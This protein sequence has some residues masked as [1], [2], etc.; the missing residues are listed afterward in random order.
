L[1]D[2]KLEDIAYLDNEETPEQST[3][4]D[5]QLAFATSIIAEAVVSLAM[6]PKAWL[7]NQMQSREGQLPFRSLQASD[8]AGKGSTK[9]T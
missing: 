5:H 7:E 3:E 8:R 2:K 9:R 1:R 6:K 4:A